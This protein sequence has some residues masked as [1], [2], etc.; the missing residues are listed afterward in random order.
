MKKISILIFFLVT[1]SFYQHVGAHADGKSF[2]AR[3][4][5]GNSIDISYS[6]ESRAGE[7]TVFD[8][9]LRDKKGESLLY[10][11]IWVRIS[12]DS[13]TYLATGLARAPLGKTVL[14]YRFSEAGTYDMEVRFDKGGATLSEHTFAV[15]AE[16]E[17]AAQ[18]DFPITMLLSLLA[19]F[20]G[21]A[22]LTH[23]L[24]RFR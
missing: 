12:K 8:F 17:D 4:A 6:D 18:A 19:A 3:D 1:F 5:S 7:S 9:S 11:H 22:I 13:A 10:D 14:T 15:T 16:E 2:E 23:F 21:G 24:L 20:C